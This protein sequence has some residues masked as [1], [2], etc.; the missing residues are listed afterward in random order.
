VT[1]R[2]LTPEQRQALDAVRAAHNVKVTTRTE[3]EAWAAREVAKRV[4]AA[5]RAESQAVRHA[6]EA[7]V[8]RARIGRE[9]LAS[10]DSH[11]AVGRALAVTAEDA[12]AQDAAIKSM[13][14][15]RFRLANALERETHPLHETLDPEVRRTAL[16]IRVDWT[17]YPIEAAARG[18]GSSVDLHGFVYDK[19]PRGRKFTYL[20]GDDDQ[21]WSERLLQPPLEVAVWEQT[22][23]KAAL[24][25]LETL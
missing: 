9:G 21:A 3:A 19:G 20:D 14:Q 16:L 13:S 5:E 4:D 6:L 8:P 17:D 7:G 22:F 1:A 11:R 25:A 10:S 18:Y 12:A 24:K 2:S 15:T 23:E